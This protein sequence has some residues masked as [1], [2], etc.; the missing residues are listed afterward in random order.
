MPFRY[1]RRHGMGGRAPRFL[2]RRP[3]FLQLRAVPHITRNRFDGVIGP[4]TAAVS[5]NTNI[6]TAFADP[7]NRSTSIPNNS[8]LRSVV[9]VLHPTTMTSGKHQCLLWRRPS[10]ENITAPIASYFESAEPMT[11]DGVK[12]RQLP[13]RKVET[14]I[15]DATSTIRPFRCKWKGIMRMHEGDDVVIT[16]LD[17]T[18]ATTYNYEAWTTYTT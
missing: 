6:A 15:N 9:V 4:T 11:E 3:R 5:S 8:V 12:M 14:Y 2:S 17:T 10:L 1:N 16:V 13:M 7:A 18:T